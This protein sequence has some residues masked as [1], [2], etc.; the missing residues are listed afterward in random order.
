MATS[1]CLPVPLTAVEAPGSEVL[2]VVP[3]RQL[4]SAKAFPICESLL[5][6][7]PDSPL[8]LP[9]QPGSFSSYTVPTQEIMP[10]LGLSECDRNSSK[11]AKQ[12][13]LASGLH[14]SLP[15]LQST[16]TRKNRISPSAPEC[17]I[18][19]TQNHSPINCTCNH[20]E[21]DHPLQWLHP[22]PWLRLA[23]L[24]TSTF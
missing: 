22:V 18:Q 23:A 12:F 14:F 24:V 1:K 13:R 9:V 11:S 20:S 16:H 2:P 8:R 15:C 10:L 6:A 17:N 4:L 7:S 5:V 3:F 21:C 19:A